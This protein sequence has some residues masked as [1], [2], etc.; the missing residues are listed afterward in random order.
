MKQYHPD[1]VAT[2]GEELRKVAHDKSVEIQQ[3]YDRLRSK[4]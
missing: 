3:A 2:L 1:R 4:R